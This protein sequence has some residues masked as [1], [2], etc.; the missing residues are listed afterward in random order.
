MT[1]RMT[2]FARERQTQSHFF[3]NVLSCCAVVSILLFIIL[4]TSMSSCSEPPSRILFGSCNSQAYPQPLWPAIVARNATAWVW[5]GDAIYSDPVI[6]H[7]FFSFPPRAIINHPTPES[8]HQL[9]QDQ[10]QHEGYKELLEQEM[11][12]TGTWDDHDFGKNN[13]DR[14]FPLKKESAIA[15]VN[16]LGEPQ[17][18]PMNRRAHEGH[19]VYGVKLIDFER[20]FGKQVLSEQEA[21][22]DPDVINDESSE[23]QQVPYSKHSVAV[24][25]L[26]VRSFKTPWT[27]LSLDPDGD[28]LGE[29]QWKWLEEALQRSNAAVNVVVQGLQVHADRHPD[30]NTAEAWSRMPG[31]Q[32]RLYDLL[33]EQDVPSILVSGDVH[34]A[35]LMRKDCR[36]GS[37]TKTLPEVTTSGMTHSWGTIF[38]SRPDSIFLCKYPYANW[39]LKQAM[40]FAHYINPLK[41]VIIS[42]QG[43]LQYSLDLNFAEFEWD[44][45]KNAVT[46]RILGEEG[47]ELLNAEWS[48]DDLKHGMPG[49][50][51]QERDYQAVQKSY[52]M[53]GL[54]Q[55]QW[56]CVNYRGV[57]HPYHRPFALTLTFLMPTTMLLLPMIV[58]LVVSTVLVK[59]VVWNSKP[60]QT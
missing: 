13:G 10:K 58:A 30:A 33:L 37:I 35:E 32:Q 1:D 45:S 6:G 27:K 38:C 9:Y 52:E 41:D 39:V 36:K 34:M 15:F 25:A 59:R 22:I 11:F 18:S 7:D 46:V 2:I 44:W 4:Y 40:H 5:A 8:L 12:V 21:G 60:T 54:P 28:F 29:R 51:A 49:S 16:F 31:A 57:A 48:L 24:F 42:D 14:T 26:D 20:P 50:M 53:L 19:G 55:S 47:V 43:Q 3:A 56:T 17:G 23:Q